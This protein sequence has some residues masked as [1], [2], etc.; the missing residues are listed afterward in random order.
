M[1][2][3]IVAPLPRGAAPLMAGDDKDQY[4]CQ[5][6]SDQ[7]Y[8]NGADEC[9]EMGLRKPVMENETYNSLALTRK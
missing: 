5:E 9:I 2:V 3:Q 4:G 8:H 7:E 6:F 1:L